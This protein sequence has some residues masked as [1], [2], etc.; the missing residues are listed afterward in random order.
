VLVLFA[1]TL[2]QL[3]DAPSLG[4]DSLIYHLSLPAFWLQDGLLSS[5]DLVF[6][7][8]HAEHDPKLT[9]VLSALLMWVCGDEGLTWLIQP[10]SFVGVLAVFLR[11]A[12]LIG[13]SRSLAFALTSLLFLFPPFFLN[14]Q[15]GNNDLVLTL[16]WAAL[17]F[18][19]L[20]APARPATGFGWVVG[21]LALA[22]ASKTVA[23][24][25]AAAALPA[26]LV[27]GWRLR[28]RPWL[29]AVAG[30]LLLASCG[31]YLS[32]WVAFGNP[33][34]P[35]ELRV[36]GAVV[37]PGLYDFG[38]IRVSPWTRESLASLLVDGDHQFA[39]KAPGSLVLWLGFLV[40]PLTLR[41]RRR[42]RGSR[43]V[44]LTLLPLTALLLYFSLVPFWREHRLLFPVYYSL[45]LGTAAAL[46]FVQRDLRRA[47]RR[48]VVAGVCLAVLGVRLWQEG[49]L[50][51]PV[52]IAAAVL[53]VPATVWWPL[54][55]QR[56]RLAVLV[57]GVVVGVG[58]LA[59]SWYP[60][61][62]NARASRREAAY[63]S[64]YAGLGELWNLVE[65]RSAERG[66]TVAYS[67]TPMTYPL[68]GSR[69][70]NRVRYVPTSPTDRPRPVGLQ[71]GDSFYAQMAEERRR[72]FDATFW[73]DT[74]ERARVD[75]LL[76]HDDLGRGGVVRELATV[77][78]NPER[79]RLLGSGSDV[80]GR[81]AYLFELVRP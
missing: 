5:V 81:P 48:G 27:L 69:L 51:Q 57:A 72:G 25:Y 22:L 38:A 80:Y 62:Q 50:A 65:A 47:G 59:P 73:L 46:A 68:F 18:G 35:S 79:F 75:V 56:R 12:R 54:P 16:G 52:V 78:A 60:A 37:A 71:A 15:L 31:S 28:R 26:L 66:L 34:F 43:L 21:G 20:L 61:Y 14:T 36:A 63:A 40:A 10:L 24:I 76:L 33:F 23:V 29:L 42:A 6:H 49:F 1:H 11:T 4:T 70:Q 77:R 39:P 67:G 7:G 19:L 32:N 64:H 17:C 58:A 74:L 30:A 53:A 8:H 55:S 13:C 41:F 44:A 3:S 45:W 9:Q 2:W